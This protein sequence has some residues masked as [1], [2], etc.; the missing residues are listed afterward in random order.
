MYIS[1][2]FDKIV[3]FL[4]K[5][6]NAVT[7][8][9]FDGVAVCFDEHYK[10]NGQ[11]IKRHVSGKISKLTLDIDKDNDCV[12]VTLD[13]DNLRSDFLLQKC[14]GNL[15]VTERFI[16]DL[17]EDPETGL[18][19]EDEVELDIE[20]ENGVL[21]ALLEAAE[22]ICGLNSNE[23]KEYIVAEE[24]L[25]SETGDV[26]DSTILFST[27]DEQEAREYAG[28]HEIQ[29]HRKTQVAIWEMEEGSCRDS[30][31]VKKNFQE[32]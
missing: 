16:A 17:G 29:D 1:K 20:A 11:H 28:K 14:K 15:T 23:D 27:Y 2:R 12:E 5:N 26:E 3:S 18:R 10:E 7:A 24:Y 4:E 22:H 25:N 32:N 9:S 6:G 8:N 19:D 30:W 13:M 31:I 21:D